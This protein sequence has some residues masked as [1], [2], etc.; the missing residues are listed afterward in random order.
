MTGKL[1][2]IIAV[3]LLTL[4][5]AFAISQSMQKVPADSSAESGFQAQVTLYD[6]KPK[7]TKYLLYTQDSFNAAA[8]QKRV[9]YFHAPWCPTCKVANAE[10][11]SKKDQ[12]PSGV[13]LFKTDYDT[14]GE[15]KKK[16][17]VTYQHTFVQVDAEG[18]EIS[19]WNGGGIN[20]LTTNIK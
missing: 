6:E 13:V 18:N 14:N 7:S 5:V 16:Y 3:V 19:K 9:Y 12:I 2:V 4:G 10:F 11:E 8:D 1:L 15:L 20:E 17:A